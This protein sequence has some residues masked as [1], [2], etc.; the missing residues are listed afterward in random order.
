MLNHKYRSL[1]S[2]EYFLDTC[3]SLNENEKIYLSCGSNE[4]IHLNLIQIYYN[5]D[6]YCSSELYC[7]KYRTQ[8]SRRI[9]KY[10]SLHCDDK[11]SCS[12]DKSCLKIYEPC[13]SIYG[14]YGQYITIDYSCL[15]SS[16]TYE[17]INQ[18]NYFDND[19]PVPF[20]VKLSTSDEPIIK[21]SVLRK[22]SLKHFL[23]SN[24][25]KSSPLFLI[26]II[27]V[28]LFSMFITYW[29]AG[30]VGKKFCRQDHGKKNVQTNTIQTKI[31]LEHSPED[32]T[33]VQSSSSLPVTRIYPSHSNYQ[34]H[35]PYYHYLNK[36]KYRYTPYSV[37]SYRRYINV[38]HDP[39]TGQFYSRTYNPYF[40]Y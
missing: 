30:Q 9:T 10:S 2:N 5:S 15:P 7:C 16:E 17:T 1:R 39:I 8:C 18:T 31:F 14:L 37:N 38:Q 23:I 32:K 33:K 40:N 11:S 13:A 3:C 29:L 28:F 12:I 6:E 21:N 36:N 19:Q 4:R 20:I 25:L 27:F 35:Q 26:S 34:Y 22:S 24:D